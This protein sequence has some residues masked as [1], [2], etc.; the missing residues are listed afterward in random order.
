M[1][2]KSKAM[3]A[4]AQQLS[5]ISS[6]DPQQTSRYYHD[7]MREAVKTVKSAEAQRRASGK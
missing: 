6:R 2:K 1:A 7:V 3:T 4:S 5:Q